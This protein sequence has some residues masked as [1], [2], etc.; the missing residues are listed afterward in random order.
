MAANNSFIQQGIDIV[1]KAIEADQAE[2][3]AKALGLYRDALSRLTMGLKYETNPAKKKLVLDRV[4]GYMKRA[5]ELKIYLDKEKEGKENTGANKAGDEKKEGGDAAGGRSGSSN[6]IDDE[7]KKKL[8]GALSGAVLQE[9]PN[10]KWEDVAGLENAKESLKETVLMP[11]MFPALF[12]GKRVPFKGIL[13]YGPPG[14]CTGGIFLICCKSVCHLPTP[15][16]FALS[17]Y[18]R[19]THSTQHTPRH[20]TNQERASRT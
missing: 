16:C 10:V 5:E 18:V 14:T 12:T 4:D 11:A 7:D 8:R 17:K 13:L 20:N 9:K 6:S 19:I 2:D 1:A 3:H 15:L